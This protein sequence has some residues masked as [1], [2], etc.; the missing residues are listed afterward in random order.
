MF[1]VTVRGGSRAAQGAIPGDTVARVGAYSLARAPIPNPVFPTSQTDTSATY[2]FG[3]PVVGV[4]GTQ[5]AGFDVGTA[6][7]AER[8]STAS[9]HHRSSRVVMGPG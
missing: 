9:S 6:L 7:W 8:P 4:A 5:S 3:R 1:G 2:D